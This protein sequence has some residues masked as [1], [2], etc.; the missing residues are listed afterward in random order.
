MK[1]L[2]D[3]VKY[4]CNLDVELKCLFVFGLE[5]VGWDVCRGDVKKFLKDKVR[6]RL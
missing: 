1:F 2:E 5:F 6:S 3:F 4:R